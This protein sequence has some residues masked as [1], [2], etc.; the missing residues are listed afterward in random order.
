MSSEEIR[1]FAGECKLYSHLAW[2]DFYLAGFPRTRF[3]H[4]PAVGLAKK[5]VRGGLYFEPAGGMPTMTAGTPSGLMLACRRTSGV[6]PGFP[7]W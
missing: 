1:D 4:A 6:S 2:S 3:M 5:A 7:H